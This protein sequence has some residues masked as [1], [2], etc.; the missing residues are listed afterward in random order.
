MCGCSVEVLYVYMHGTLSF[1]IYWVRRKK[2]YRWKSVEKVSEK[3]RLLKTL[4]VVHFNELVQSWFITMQAKW[5]SAYVFACVRVV[6]ASTTFPFYLMEWIH[7]ILS[8]YGVCVFFWYFFLLSN[9]Q[10]NSFFFLLLYTHYII[11]V[12]WKCVSKVSNR[13]HG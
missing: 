13:F 4:N 2:N 10:L 1:T 6:W 8:L 9:F 11:P 7:C 5:Q 12:C 3:K